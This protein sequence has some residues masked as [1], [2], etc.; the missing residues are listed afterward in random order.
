MTKYLPSIKDEKHLHQYNITPDSDQKSVA[1]FNQLRRFQKIE[2]ILFFWAIGILTIAMLAYV[3][4]VF[5]HGNPDL[6]KGLEFLKLEAQL[7]GQ[8]FGSVFSVLFLL[9]GFFALVSVQLGIYDITAR[10]FVYAFV[11]LKKGIKT[12]MLYNLGVLMQLGI[13]IIILLL[14]GKEPLWLITTGAIINAFTMVFIVLLTMVMNK[15]LLPKAYAPSLV[16]TVV[17]GLCALFYVFLLV[18]NLR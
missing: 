9:I 4:Y 16:T 8:S 13:G 6:P 5:L 18:M 2:N 17:L 15:K 1:N 14:G 7:L 10:I 3:S 11:K 12:S